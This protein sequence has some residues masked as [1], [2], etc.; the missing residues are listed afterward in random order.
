MFRFWLFKGVHLNN[1][2]VFGDDECKNRTCY[3]TKVLV[4]SQ[5]RLPIRK[6]AIK[7]RVGFSPTINGPTNSAIGIPSSGMDEH[8]F[9][10]RRPMRMDA[11]G[12][13]PAT[14]LWH[15]V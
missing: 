14:P 13:E 3:T 11:A 6:L 7:H 8:G 5:V 12:I 9:L 15:R 10:S 4:L 2:S 1:L